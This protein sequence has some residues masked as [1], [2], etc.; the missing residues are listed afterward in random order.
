MFAIVIQPLVPGPVRLQHTTDVVTKTQPYRLKQ[1]DSLP[2]N[3]TR[4]AGGLE[5]P[6]CGSEAT[7]KLQ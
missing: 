6:Q 7:A 3:A 4:E 2:L 5:V 1:M